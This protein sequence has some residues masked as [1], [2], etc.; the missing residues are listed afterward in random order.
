MFAFQC[1]AVAVWSFVCAPLLGCTMGSGGAL[2]A[3]ASWIS[4]FWTPNPAKPSD[5]GYFSFMSDKTE[6]RAF[7]VCFFSSALLP[8]V[9]QKRPSGQLR[10]NWAG[11]ACKDKVAEETVFSPS[12]KGKLVG[13]LGSCCRTR[14]SNGKCYECPTIGKHPSLPSVM[15]IYIYILWYTY[16]YIRRAPHVTYGCRKL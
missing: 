4:D 8:S 6:T 1:V 7:A 10:R 2:V 9:P 16:R 12:S 3:G 14:N 15:R 11:R 5:D 13:D